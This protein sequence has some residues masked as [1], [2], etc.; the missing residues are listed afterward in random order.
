M[1]GPITLCLVP[2]VYQLFHSQISSHAKLK[3]CQETAQI[4]PIRSCRHWAI[5]NQ[6]HI[7]KQSCAVRATDSQIAAIYTGDWLRL[8]LNKGTWK[9]SV[10]F[11]GTN[12]VLK[13]EFQLSNDLLLI[14]VHFC[15]LLPD[16]QWWLV[17]ISIT[18]FSF[19]QWRLHKKL[20]W[21]VSGKTSGIWINFLVHFWLLVALNVQE[22]NQLPDAEIFYE[23][24]RLASPALTRL[25]IRF[26]YFS[27][28]LRSWLNSVEERQPSTL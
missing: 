28:H 14:L 17:G 1:L 15:S 16:A 9:L 7:R 23:Q 4:K 10:W 22:R 27:F 26:V 5:I 18:A 20:H 11:S 8:S 19:L 3:S 24:C 12:P 21:C 6:I 2:I 25:A 13:G